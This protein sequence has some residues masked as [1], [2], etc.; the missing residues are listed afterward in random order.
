MHDFSRSRLSRGAGDLWEEATRAR[1]LDAV[2]EGTLPE[3][4]FDRWLVQDYRFVF[5]LSRFVALTAAKT[6]R[7]AQRVVIGGLAALDE[8]LEWFEDHA[9]KRGLDLDAAPHPACRRYADYLIAAG[10]GEPM[11]ILLAILF[12]VEVAYTAGWGRLEPEGPYAEFIERWTHPEFQAYVERLGELAD[13]H[14]HP[15][16]QEHFDRVMRHERAFWRMTWEG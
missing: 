2:G 9:E 5:G 10:Y 12:G 4:A 7:P 15:D 3:E 13:A 8:E 11:E 14:E 6:P 1:F 16:Q